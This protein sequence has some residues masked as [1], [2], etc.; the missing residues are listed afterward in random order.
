M[1]PQDS[2][3]PAELQSYVASEAVR[4]GKIVQEA[5]AKGIE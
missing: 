4:W 2:P 3:T 1:I 5:G